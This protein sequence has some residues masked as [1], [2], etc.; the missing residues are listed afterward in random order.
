[1]PGLLTLIIVALVNL[2]VSG[3]ELFIGHEIDYGGGQG[4]DE[5]GTQAGPKSGQ[6]FVPADLH[7]SIPGAGKL[8]SLPQ[9]RQ[10]GA[11][12]PTCEEVVHQPVR[13]EEALVGRRLLRLHASL[14]HV[15][16]RH[17]AGRDHGPGAGRDYLLQR[18]NL[19]SRI[20]EQ[21]SVTRLRVRQTVDG[22]IFPGASFGLEI[23]AAG[24]TT[25]ST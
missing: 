18:P 15:Q 22:V 21:L 10:L 24:G 25:T 19:E 17:E 6:S 3:L 11:I 16:G 2:E 7:Q 4:G 5:G 8:W 20:A 14:D 12:G 1:M 13:I 23:V 9:A